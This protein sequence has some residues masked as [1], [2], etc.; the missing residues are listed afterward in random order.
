MNWAS[1]RWNTHGR[2]AVY[3]GVLGSCVFSLC[4]TCSP[5]E[6]GHLG[7]R[8][9]LRQSWHEDHQPTCCGRAIC[10]LRQ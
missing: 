10:W 1:L 9:G 5:D 7:R 8:T 4:H 3:T 2:D 6:R